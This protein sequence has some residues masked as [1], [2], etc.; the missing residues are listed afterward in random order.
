MSSNSAEKG[1]F[2]DRKTLAIKELAY[3][4]LLVLL[5]M[6]A[7]VWSGIAIWLF[8]RTFKAW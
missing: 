7:S 6:T 3:T 2:H 4:I 1:A 5:V 8:G